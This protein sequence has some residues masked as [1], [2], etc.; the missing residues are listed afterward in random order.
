MVFAWEV[1]FVKVNILDGAYDA[2]SKCVS[3]Y[4]HHKSSQVKVPLATMEQLLQQVNV[5][6]L[7]HCVGNY[8]PQCDRQQKLHASFEN[9]AT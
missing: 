7:Q 6:A 1:A 4:H 2:T 3:S 9:N 5:L 8:A